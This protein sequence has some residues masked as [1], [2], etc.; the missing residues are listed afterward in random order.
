MSNR[1]VCHAGI[2][3]P[4]RSCSYA[5]AD[6][7]RLSETFR[8]DEFEVTFSQRFFEHFSDEDIGKLIRE[9]LTVSPI[10][11][12]SVPSKWYGVRDFGNERLMT[13]GEWNSG[14]QGFQS[15]FNSRVPSQGAQH[16]Y[17]I[18]EFVCVLEIATVEA[19]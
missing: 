17:H 9:Q 1:V 13:A 15:A 11:I 10:V 6:A 2:K 12:F 19:V 8:R 18:E 4:N 5:F 3:L 16:A 7:F 14:A